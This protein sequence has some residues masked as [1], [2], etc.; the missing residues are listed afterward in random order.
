MKDRIEKMEVLLD[1]LAK[2]H[3]FRNV[4]PL[5]VLDPHSIKKIDRFNSF[6]SSWTHSLD[7]ADAI[8]FSSD[9]D[10]LLR[11]FTFF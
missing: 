5:K 6:T 11:G 1:K 10:I 4:F 7:K 3:H 2:S 9:Y 8:E